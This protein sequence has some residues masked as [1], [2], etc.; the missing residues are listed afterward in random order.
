[1]PGIASLF[2]IGKQSL[3]AN[4]SAIE[5]VGNNI[6]NANTEGYSR[7]AVRFEDGYYINYTPGQLGTGVN[8]AEVI[9][10]FDEF[11]EILYNTK[12]SEQQ[13]W[14][15]LHENLQNVEMIFNESNAEGVNAALSAFWAD[16]QTLSTNPEDTSVRAALL[17]HASNLEQAIGVVQ[18]DL[19]RLQGQTDDTIDAEVKEINTLLQSIAELNNQITVTEETGKNNANGLRDQRATL[20]RDLAEK[21]DINYIDNGLGNV[22]I[23]TKAGHTLVDGTSAFRLAFESAPFS[24]SLDS[25]STFTGDV[26]FDGKSSSEYTLEIVNGGLMSDGGLT[27][28]VS[29]DGGKTW[30]K[31]ENG[32]GVFTITDEGVLL[33]DG[34]GSVLFSPKA[35][36]TLTKGDRFQ[37]LPNKSVFWYETSASKINITPQVLSNGEDNERR[38][39]GGSLA[40]YFQ[41]RDSSIGGYLEKLDAFA[42][43]LA[44]EVNRL[45]SQGTG[46]ERFEEVT[47]TYGLVDKDADLGVDAGLIFGEKLESGNLMIGVYDKD[48]GAMVQFQGLDFNNTLAG[49]QNFDP[50]E[51]SLQDVV[52]A[53][54]NTF[55]ALTAS[56]LDNHLQ[57]S[58]DA[59]H[60]FAFGS[61]TTG[62]LAALGI[63]TFFEGSDARTLS[64]NNSVRSNSSRINTGH[65]NGAGEMNE[66]DNTT[67]AAIA[68]L[69]TK[70]VSTRTVIEGTSRQTLGEYYSTLVAKAGSDTQSAKFNAEYQEALAND[71]R[72]RQ[73]SVSGVNLDE[74]MTNLIK[75]QHAY[76]A[77]AKLITTAE[78]M[79]EVL[80]GLK[81]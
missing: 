27:F 35:G 36:D 79:L 75:F 9:R 49:I 42:K 10:Y 55:G 8:A 78:S 31:D 6:S 39:T 65:I 34:K 3:F 7:Q 72:S 47:G 33:P 77:A 16:W 15:K 63:N 24:A 50:T 40:G 43:S 62:L 37:I 80:L 56:V 1:M 64:V 28:K 26:S 23:T 25:A 17:G 21:I 46:L 61:D 11:T 58:S 51:H 57:I 76:T 67:A 38:L 73:E 29:V 53:I 12:S 2:N 70:A 60:D 5:V 66:G 41:F 81:N 19:Q 18:G 4:Q 48:T 74:E 71:L 32:V 69:Q 45:H 20:V 22:T 14:Q 52:D 13:R 54:N 30:L 59:D 68:A 44:W